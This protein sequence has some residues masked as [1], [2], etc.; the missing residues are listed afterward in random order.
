MSRLKS[1][2]KRL[3]TVE[4]GLVRKNESIWDALDRA[5]DNL[6]TTQN[7]YLY[8]FDQGFTLEDIN[9]AFQKKEDAERE[10]V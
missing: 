6:E 8:L 9:G 7:C 1:L 10:A 3:Q 4:K 5:P 2:S